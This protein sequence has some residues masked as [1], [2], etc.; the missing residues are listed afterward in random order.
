MAGANVNIGDETVEVIATDLV[1]F[2]FDATDC[3]DLFPPLVALAAHCRGITVL[4]GTGRLR[5]KE[6]DRAVVLRENF[7]RL[8]VKIDLENDRMIIHGG[9]VRS[10]SIHACNDHRIAMAAAII[11]IKA[12]GIIEIEGSDCVSK[13]YPDFFDDYLKMGGVINE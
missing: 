3:P 11:G 13:S 2:D 12:N 7:A 4:T 6:S 9:K 8:G 10:G 1:P 5:S